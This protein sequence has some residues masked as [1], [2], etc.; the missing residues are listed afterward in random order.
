M[1]A[2]LSDPGILPRNLDPTPQRKY[3]ENEDAL[4]A[5]G[6]KGVSGGQFVAETKYLRV[7]DGV[8]GSKC[9][10]TL[11]HTPSEGSLS[12]KRASI[13]Q[14]AKLARFTDHRGRVI[15][16]CAIIVSN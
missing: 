11:S 2:S 3:I 9:T 6:E 4:T 10:F 12:V 8:V 14:G 1:K 5:G 16:G 7:R 15:V 13:V